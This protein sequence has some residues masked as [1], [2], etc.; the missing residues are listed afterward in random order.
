MSFCLFLLDDLLEVTLLDAA[1]VEAGL[2]LR[3]TALRV[4]D[5]I[6]VQDVHDLLVLLRGLLL[7]DVVAR[8]KHL[9]AG[10]ND[11]YDAHVEVFDQHRQLRLL[12]FVLP[13]Q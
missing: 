8:H 7:H 3:G 13:N 12:C 1:L 4:E 10:A 11:V 2:L 6:A 5:L 9:R